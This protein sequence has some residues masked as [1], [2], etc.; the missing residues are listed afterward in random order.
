MGLSVA[1]S[2]SVASSFETRGVAA[3][4]RMRSSLTLMVRSH[5]KRGVSNHEAIRSAIMIQSDRIMLYS[6][7][8]EE[9]VLT[10]S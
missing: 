9:E 3:L 6:A 2:S 10:V 1:F 5:A 8:D 4:L 7:G